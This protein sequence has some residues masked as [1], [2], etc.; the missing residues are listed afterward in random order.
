MAGN[1]GTKLATTCRVQDAARHPNCDADSLS[2]SDGERA[3]VRG[4]SKPTKEQ[5][6]RARRLR[7]KSTWAE[8]VLWRMLRNE[9]FAGYKF[10]RQ[11]P[12]EAYTL[13]FYCAEAR[14]V[15]EAD[16]GGHGHPARQCHDVARDA[17][18]RSQGIL[19]KRIW[20]SQLRREPQV[21]RDNLW[22]L[23]QER[24]PHPG[25]VKPARRVTSRVLDPDRPSAKTPHPALS[26]S[27]GE[28]ESTANAIVTSGD[29]A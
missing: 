17:F 20:N 9:R 16:G 21:V 7:L 23:L 27:D 8:K 15:V 11:H 28:R 6:A 13:D 22:I 24:A 18:L 19:V 10:R 14:L 12:Y 26:P 25:N 4:R 29:Q 1:C 3:G 2:P 5:I